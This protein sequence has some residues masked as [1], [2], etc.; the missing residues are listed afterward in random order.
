MNQ[1]EQFLRIRLGIS[2]ETIFS[3]IVNEATIQTVS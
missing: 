2:D 3:Q 1:I